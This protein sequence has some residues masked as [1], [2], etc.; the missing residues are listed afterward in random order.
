MQHLLLFP[1]SA[2]EAMNLSELNAVN[3]G[4][5]VEEKETTVKDNAAERKD[6]SGVVS[7]KSA[8]T[9][10]RR[11][12]AVTREGG[13]KGDSFRRGDGEVSHSS[14]K[15]TREGKGDKL[16]PRDSRASTG[17]CCQLCDI[18]CKLYQLYAY[19]RV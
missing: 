7:A 13:S 12:S 18:Y 10:N 2:D 3:A 4:L 19:I 14:S 5:H 11:A 1:P 6:T 17:D 8:P 9:M 16:G 15:A